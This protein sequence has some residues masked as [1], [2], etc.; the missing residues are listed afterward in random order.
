M[1]EK[2][3]IHVICLGNIAR[4]PAGQLLLQHYCDLEKQ[5]RNSKISVVV[6][7]SGLSGGLYTEME[8]YSAEYLHTKGIKISSFISQLTTPYILK[9]QDLILCMEQYMVDKVSQMNK[10]GKILTFKAAAG[11]K[12]DIEDPYGLYKGLYFKIMEEINDCAQKIAKRFYNG[13]IMDISGNKE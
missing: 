12:G 1:K 3:T 13:E 4:S 10:S 9:D 11:L 5:K 2:Y 8:P 7:S 6:S